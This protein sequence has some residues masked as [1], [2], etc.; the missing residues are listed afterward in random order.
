[1]RIPIFNLGFCPD[2]ALDNL[3][4]DADGQLWAAGMQKE[5]WIWTFIHDG[6]QGYP[7]FLQPWPICVTRRFYHLPLLKESPS[8]LVQIHSM[9][10]S[11]K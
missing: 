6:W 4:I 11:I 3:A 7:R 10:K 5:I 9:V 1:M 2:H 8:I